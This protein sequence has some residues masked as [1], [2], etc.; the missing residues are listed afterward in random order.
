MT[1]S[2]RVVVLIDM[3]CFYCQVEEK[4]NPELK[5]KPI[6]VVQ[7]NQWQGGGIIAVNYIARSKGVTRHMRGDEAKKMCPEIQLPSVPCVRGKADISKY[8]DAGKDVAHVLQE[9][10]PLLERASIDEAYLDI[11]DVVASKIDC[12]TKGERIHDKF[13]PNTYILGY[14]NIESFS[15][16]VYDRNELD[17]EMSGF[18]Q[19]HSL[20]LFV[21]A[22][23]VSE[24]RTA[25]YE[26]TGFRC[27]AGIAHNKI[28]AKL[29]CGM[30]KPNK[31][32]V[33]PKNCVANLFES[34]SINKIRHL[35]GKFGDLVCKTLNISIMKELEN[36][37][38]KDLQKKFDEKNGS[39][40]YNIARGID[41]EPV[42]PRFNAKS[43][44]CCKKFAGKMALTDFASLSHWL[45]ELASEI[46]ERLESDSSENNRYPTQMVVS[47]TKQV[48]KGKNVSGSRS[49]NLSRE[50]IFCAASLAVNSLNLIRKDSKPFCVPE[51]ETSDIPQDKMVLVSPITFLGISVGKFE[52]M[53]NANSKGKNIQDFFGQ[54]KKSKE[55]NVEVDKSSKEANE[56]QKNVADTTHLIKEQSINSKA[57]GI[58]HVQSDDSNDSVQNSFFVKYFKKFTTPAKSNTD[59]VHE[60]SPGASVSKLNIDEQKSDPNVSE[61]SLDNE[62]NPNEDSNEKREIIRSRNTFSISK[63]FSSDTL[64][65]TNLNNTPE[66]TEAP[67]KTVACDKCNAHIVESELSTHND[68]HFAMSLR[69]EERK[70]NE[71]INNSK[72]ISKPTLDIK[73]SNKRKRIDEPAPNNSIIKLFSKITSQN[74]QKIDA[75]VTHSTC[76]ECGKAIE[77]SKYQE[78]LD[79]HEARRLQIELNK[80]IV[81]NRASELS[82][83]HKKRKN[84]TKVSTIETK[85]T[86]SISSFFQK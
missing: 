54:M 64:N 76:T 15:S 1:S 38:E 33:L 58:Q 11:T 29:V 20:K 9:F 23:I 44:G 25:V 77:E 57:N 7:Y 45:K 56:I 60:K 71:T 65:K 34:L 63:F 61:N 51:V 66:E 75:N 3:D 49:V 47:F 59:D 82:V 72:C 42:T 67:Q 73:H 83:G 70:V 86:K 50:E 84:E 16:D 28:M 43:I 69:N 27:S 32:T 55:P 35:G 80:P 24:I 53:S 81:T 6:A 46:Q 36:F 4:L 10:T 37:S 19:L 39:W 74:N 41:N 85:T 30:N 17:C 31:Q 21:G 78:H 52:N 22:V 62:I 2:E 68:Y 5:G 13:L 8:R 18:D 26:K 12:Y 79:Y 48:T 14:D 40:L